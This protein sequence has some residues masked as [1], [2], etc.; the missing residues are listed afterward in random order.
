[1]NNNKDDIPPVFDRLPNDTTIVCAPL[2]DA[3]VLSAGG[4]NVVFTQTIEQVAIGEFII[5]RTWT[6]TDSCGNTSQVI[7]QITWIPDTF[8][9]C[10]I[11]MPEVFECNSHGVVISSLVTGGM[12]AITY[13]WEVVGEKCFIQ[14]GQGTP[15]IS[16]YTGF[17]DVKIILN[18]TDSF[19]CV[20]MCMIIL[21]CEIFFNPA[22]STDE[23]PGIPAHEDV[24]NKHGH[25]YDSIYT[26]TISLSQI[27]TWPN[28]VSGTLNLSFLSAS[29]SIVMVTMTNF[30]GQNVISENFRGQTGKNEISINTHD[31]HAGTYLM[32][33]TT[34]DELYNQLIIVVRPD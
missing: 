25:S 14:G 9:E 34:E 19:G 26:K 3:P 11:L 15:E 27:R 1:M 6:A 4:S 7:Q 22:F 33:I 2:F 20:S 29:E 13:E 8:L 24:T 23:Q 10:N 28:P 12:G 5:T 31:M 21:D 18:V 32:Q 17:S 16:I 30:L